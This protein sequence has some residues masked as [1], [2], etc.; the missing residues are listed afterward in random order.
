MPDKK[1]IL[2][3]EDEPDIVRWLTVLFENHGY[4][5][6]S[7]VDGAEGVQ[8]AKAESP[9]LITLDIS[10]PKESGIKM[11]HNL[12]KSPELENTPVIMVTVATPQLDNFLARLKG[13]KQPAGF[14]EKPVKE[15]EL[16]AKVKEIAAGM[17][18]QILVSTHEEQVMPF[19]DTLIALVNKHYE[20]DDE[21]DDDE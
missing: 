17:G 14:F 4:E 1:K 6:V 2:V 7:A 8:K 12:L 21:D 15:E 13:Q 5:V 19:L 9:D 18:L 11:Y 16:L 3:V 20:E 10:M